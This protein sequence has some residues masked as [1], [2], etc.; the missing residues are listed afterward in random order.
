V[1]PER[2][3]YVDELYAAGCEHDARHA[4]RLQRLR[5]VEPETA[6]MLAVLVHATGA[7]DVLEIG[8]SN[9]YSTL[10]LADALQDAG[11][12]LVSLDVD[13]QRT[14]LARG[15]LAA[16]G[17]EGVVELRTE[18]AA[19]ALRGFADR[20]FGLLFLDA[21][22]DAYPGYWP[23]L[24]RVLVPGGLLVVDNAVSH[25]D[26][27]AAFAALV[28]ADARVLSALVPVGAGALLVVRLSAPA[29]R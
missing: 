23:E 1:R 24:V 29:T 4:D 3:A 28:E 26:E 11:G 14:A 2:R 5:N 21:E 8:T 25:A 17:L 7:R 16:V 22:R 20:A 10:W 27:L 9:G 13:A 12:R 18:D 15:H 19:Q 6:A